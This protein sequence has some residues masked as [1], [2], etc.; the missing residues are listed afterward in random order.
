MRRVVLPLLFCVASLSASA[1]VLAAPAPLPRR[2]TESPGMARER[3]LREC[4]RRLDELNVKWKVT[5]GGY[6]QMV[7]FSVSHPN[8]NSAMGGGYPVSRDDLVG[9]LQKVIRRVE[10]FLAYP[11]RL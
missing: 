1:P 3:Q 6:G 4:Y 7:Q 9:T 10:S 5:D 11:N 2:Q 8:G